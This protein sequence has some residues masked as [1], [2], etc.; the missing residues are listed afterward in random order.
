MGALMKNCNECRHYKPGGNAYS[1]AQCTS[2]RVSPDFRGALV[3]AHVQR[4]D[5][6]FAAWLDGT[7][8]Q[9]GRFFEKKPVPVVQC[10]PDKETIQRESV[11]AMYPMGDGDET[12]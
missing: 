9:R 12:Q 8:G 1:N 2:P 4:W 11:R 5:G 7:C 6:W 3:I 10:G